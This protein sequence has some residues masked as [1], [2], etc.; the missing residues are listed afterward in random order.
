MCTSLESWVGEE[1]GEKR[2]NFLPSKFTRGHLVFFYNGEFERWE[3]KKGREGGREGGEGN[4]NSVEW[5]GHY[6][7][8]DR[9]RVIL[10]GWQWIYSALFARTHIRYTY[11][12]TGSFYSHDIILFTLEF[13]IC[14]LWTQ[15][16]RPSKGNN[17]A[18]KDNSCQLKILI[19]VTTLLQVTLM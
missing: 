12:S 5:L 11:T 16:S 18:I 2:I 13:H 17:Q 15:Q 14:A 10:S 7:Y 4:I 9:H 3:K 19:M 6:P 1:E 8:K